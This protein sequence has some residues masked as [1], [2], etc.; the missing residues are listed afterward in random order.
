MGIGSRSVQGAPQWAWLSWTM[1]TAW[2]RGEVR[3]SMSREGIDDDDRVVL[4]H[5]AAFALPL[6]MGSLAWVFP[7]VRQWLVHHEVLLPAAQ[8]IWVLPGLDAGLD[9]ARLALVVVIVL[10]V[11]AA[12]IWARLRRRRP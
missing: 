4:V 9:L 6:V 11:V 10:L 3:M 1:L 7:A 8:A 12:P 5:L 2:M